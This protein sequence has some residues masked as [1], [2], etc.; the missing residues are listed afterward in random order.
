MASDSA[1]TL[2]EGAAPTIGQQPMTKIYTIGADMLYASTGAV[3]V[4]QLIRDSLD[5]AVRRQGPPKGSISSGSAKPHS[6]EN[7]RSG[8]AALRSSFRG[9]SSHRTADGRDQCTVQI[10]HCV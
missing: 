6:R 4:S 2:A 5:K 1:A 8:H 10:A 7:R 3:G 9:R